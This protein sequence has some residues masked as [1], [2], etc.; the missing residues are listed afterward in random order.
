MLTEAQVK[1]LG[2]LQPAGSA[3]A[4]AEIPNPDIVLPS[5][6]VNV[7][8]TVCFA[9]TATATVPETEGVATIELFAPVGPLTLLIGLPGGLV[10]V[11]PLPPLVTLSVPLL[12]L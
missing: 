2:P 5:L 8:L 6:E 1:L 10:P 4:P 3:P 9:P 12:S 11:P 7:M